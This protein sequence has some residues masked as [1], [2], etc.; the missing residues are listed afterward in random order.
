MRRSTCLVA[1]F[2]R[3]GIAASGPSLVAFLVALARGVLIHTTIW[4]SLASLYLFAGRTA[5]V[6]GVIVAA[7][8]SML[9]LL[10]GRVAIATAEAA[11]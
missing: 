6:V 10:R 1:I 5:G 9:V 11:T 8:V 7:S 3:D 2:Y 4:F